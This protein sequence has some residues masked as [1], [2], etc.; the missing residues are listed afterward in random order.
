MQP[1]PP[2]EPPPS[3]RDG[4]ILLGGTRNTTDD[5]GGCGCCGCCSGCCSCC[6]LGPHT[7]DPDNC[8]CVETNGLASPPKLCRSLSETADPVWYRNWLASVDLNRTAV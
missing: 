1:H 4:T 6:G 2:L 7:A 3:Q 5:L 8:H